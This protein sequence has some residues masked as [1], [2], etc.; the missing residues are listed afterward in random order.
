MSGCSVVG[1]GF[2]SSS[3]ACRDRRRNARD[4]N[5]L[6]LF[7]RLNLRPGCGW[8]VAALTSSS[9]GRNDS[10]EAHVGDAVNFEDG[11]NWLVVATIRDEE[12]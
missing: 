10:D 5:V 7:R 9:G 6:L 12:D 4:A 3:S 1:F 11:V 2:C 8:K